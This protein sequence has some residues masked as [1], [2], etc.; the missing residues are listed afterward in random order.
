MKKQQ[1]FATPLTLGLLVVLL[2][3]GGYYWMNHRSSSNSPAKTLSITASDWS[4]YKWMGIEPTHI[5]FAEAATPA[6]AITG[7]KGF[8][9]FNS[10]GP[11]G[12]LRVETFQKTNSEKDFP[13]YV[14][15]NM[16]IFES[17]KFFQVAGHDAARI[18]HASKDQYDADVAWYFI[19]AG[20]K[21]II[22]ISTSG[23]SMYLYDDDQNGMSS[24]DRYIAGYQPAK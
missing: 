2:V 3:G 19:D 22:A 4:T 5:S 7:W 13:S 15:A 21:S 14:A 11:A 18:R 12:N 9:D 17:V 24:R 10:D 23:D 20:D 8:V 16:G 1:G 6:L